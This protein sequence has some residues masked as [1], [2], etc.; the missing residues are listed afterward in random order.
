M[1]D[2]QDEQVRRL[3]AEARHD[4]PMP[5]DVAARMDAVLADL[6]AEPARS[7]TVVQLAAR[8]RRATRMLV[9]AAAVVVLGVGVGQAYRGLDGGESATTAADSGVD[10]EAGRGTADELEP[11]SA[12]GSDQPGLT[13]RPF[14]LRAQ[15]F[16]EDAGR[17]QALGYSGALFDGEGA[18]PQEVPEEDAAPEAA[19]TDLSRANRQVVCE[20]GD[21]G[22]GGFFAVVYEGT[23][24]WVVLRPPAGDTQVA[25]LFLCGGEQAVRSVTLPLR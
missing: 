12:G 22:R 2:E 4:E 23:P 18:L 9:A 14:R 16:S 20:P 11:E 13:T 17:L 21:W 7:A 3:L 10:E 15:R 19:T 5:D 25:D 1:T 8:R 6:A 24:G